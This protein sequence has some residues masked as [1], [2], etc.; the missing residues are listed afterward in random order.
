MRLPA[1]HDDLEAVAGGQHRAVAV[2]EN[3]ALEAGEDMDAE[4]G[5]DLRVVE[6][7]FGDHALGAGDPL[8]GRHPLL[9][10]LE[11]QHDLARQAVA[12]TGQH[13]GGGEQHRGVGVVAAG[14]HDRHGLAL[15]G[16][17]RAARERQVD[18]LQDR[19]RVD[20]GAQRD[21]RPGS[22]PAITATTPVPAIE[23][24]SRPISAQPLG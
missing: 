1:L 20:V 7:P 9:G 19:Q 2:A 3:A 15:V 18:L 22:L 6:R 5:V 8:G 13:L 10:R 17:G 11:E 14:V 4:D 12:Q 21:R 23:R 24:G 16:P